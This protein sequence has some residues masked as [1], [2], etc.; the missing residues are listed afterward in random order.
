MESLSFSL[1]FFKSKKTDF[2]QQRRYFRQ[3][4][5][6]KQTPSNA[7]GQLFFFYLEAVSVWLRHIS[8]VGSIFLLRHLVTKFQFSEGKRAWSPQRAVLSKTMML[9]SPES[10]TAF[11][12]DWVAQ[13]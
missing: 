6:G 1:T 10:L 5:D 8:L 7:L 2:L 12:S 13:R 9:V 4:K 3:S 11:L